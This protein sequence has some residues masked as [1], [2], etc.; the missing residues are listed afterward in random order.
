MPTVSS[1]TDLRNSAHA[2]SGYDGVVRVSVG[3]YYGSGVLL[4]DGRAIL[5][6]A[7]LFSGTKSSVSVKFDTVAGLKT[8]NATS[9]R[10]HNAYDPISSNHDLAIVWLS[11]AA[12]IMAERYPLYRSS[13]EI[14][15]DFT[16]VGYGKPGTGSLGED[17]Q[18]VGPAPRVKADNHFDSEAA[19]LKDA[20]GH[21]MAWTPS[22]NTQLIAD[23][24]N[25]LSANDAL[26]R[27]MQLPHVGENEGMISRGDS[28][29]P[30]FINGA[31]AGIASYM[32]SLHTHTIYTDIDDQSNSSYGEI[33]F[34][35]RVS[36]YEQWI[37][38]SI[39]EHHIDAPTKPQEVQTKVQEGNAGTLYAYFLLQFIGVRSNSNQILSVEYTTRDGSATA[40]EDYLSSTGTLKLY[41][42]ENQAVIF[43]E[44]I[45]DT[46]FEYDETFYLDVYNPIGG[47]FGEGVEKLSVMRTIVNDDGLF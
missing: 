26:G 9:V 35:Q 27:L 15:K 18:F 10:V 20:L 16:F 7:H 19:S 3:D 14:G 42:D 12:P 25:G 1:Y 29:G 17:E 39:R 21:F 38:E 6:A 40:G 23:F 32:A 45:G 4:Y 13:D 30:A 44:I 22:A 28:G 47:S 34:W 37:D 8:I 36:N 2:G 33:G 41:P 43:I 31:V 11:Q 24:D 5:T 46:K